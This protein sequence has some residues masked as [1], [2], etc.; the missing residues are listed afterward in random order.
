LSPKNIPLGRR[1]GPGK[2][3]QNISKTHLLVMFPQKTSNPKPKMLFFWCQ[4]EDLLNP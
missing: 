3:G 2:D 1:P 4:L